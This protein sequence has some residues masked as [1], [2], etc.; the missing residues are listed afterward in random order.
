MIKHHSFLAL[1]LGLSLGFGAC[2]RG[3]ADPCSIE[4]DQVGLLTQVVD[5]HILPTYESLLG[6]HE[7]L[8]FRADAFVANPSDLGLDSLRLAFREAYLLWQKAAIFEFGPAE[9]LELRKTVNSFPVFERRL[10]EA[11]VGGNYDLEQPFYAFTR[12]YPALDYLLFK[13]DA[14]RTV[15]DFAASA[16]RGVYLKRVLAQMKT[17]FASVLADW[18]GGYGA[19]FRTTTGLATGTPMSLLVNQLSEHFETIKNQKLGDPLGVKLGY[20]ASPERVEGRYSAWSIE[21]ALASLE[22]SR[23]VFRGDGQR[24]LAA[25]LVAAAAQKDGRPLTEVIENQYR[26][27]LESLEVL[28]PNSLFEALTNNNQAV[29]TAYAHVLNQVVHLKTD[30]PSVLCI[31]IVYIDNVDDGD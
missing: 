1:I 28:R 11:I 2:E 3:G 15:A 27:A 9:V 16:N 4:F 13:D 30:L 22:A 7:V 10:E 24:G 8:E 5:G 12:G 25:Y 29:R 6:A 21:L 17:K 14:A 23:A 18:R 26:L 31:S 20:L 19:S